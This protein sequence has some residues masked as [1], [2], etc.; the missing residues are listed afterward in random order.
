LSSWPTSCAR[1]PASRY[2]PAPGS[3]C[4][5]AASTFSP[6]AA[7]TTLT[8]K[9]AGNYQTQPAWNPTSPPIQPS[10]SSRRARLASSPVWPLHP[11]TCLSCWRSAAGWTACPLPWHWLP[12]PRLLAT[13]VRKSFLQHDQASHRY[14]IHELLR[15]YGAEKLASDPPAESAARDRHSRYYCDWLGQ[16]GEGLKDTA[17]QAVWDAIQADIE[18]RLPACGPRRMGM[19]TAWRQPS[20]P[21]AGSTTLAMATT[22]RERPPSTVCGKRWPRQRADCLQPQRAPRRLRLETT[23]RLIHEAQ[24]LLDGQVLAGEDTRLERAILAYQSGYG[25]L[26]ADPAAGQQHF[27]ESL[28]LCRQVGHNLGMAYALLALGKAALRLGAVDEAR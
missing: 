12:P 1:H 3:S 7:S 19:R 13:F 24:A 4:S 8:L 14:Q 5:Y 21:S 9:P 2:W 22:S 18:C 15:Q 27:A 20:T 28:E 16:A 11:K 25:R 23:W 10:S 6:S 26:Y 17:P